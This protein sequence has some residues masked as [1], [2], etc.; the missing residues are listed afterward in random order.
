MPFGATVTA[1]GV[2]FRLW[3]PAAHAVDVGIGDAAKTAHWHAL[4]AKGG[5]WFEAMV[6]EERH[7]TRYRFRIDAGILVPDP[8]SRYNPADV[9]GAS[10]VV[11]PNR[12][13]WDDEDWH[14]R[15]WHEAVIY[16]VHV[17]TFTPGGAFGDV[18]SRLDY[19]AELGVTA[20]ELMPVADFPGKRNWGYDGALLFAP[21]AI[22]G[23]PD[24]LK[25][26]VAAAHRRGLMV[27]LDVV[28][29]HFGPEGNYL[30]VYA[31]QF[32]T[33]RHPTP[34]GAGINFDDADAAQ[35]RAFYVHNALY[36]LEEFS[37]DGLRFDAVHA[38]ADDS[39]P[40]ILTQ[41]AAAVRNGPGRER[42]IRSV[43]RVPSR[44]VGAAR[45]GT[46]DAYFCSRSSAPAWP[47]AATC[48]AVFT[49]PG[50]TTLTRI[51][52]PSTRASDML[53]VSSAAFDAAYATDEPVP[54]TEA[55]EEMLTIEPRLVLSAGAQARIICQGPTRLTRKMPRMSSADSPSRSSCLTN[56]VVPALLTSAS[57]RP[58]LSSTAFAT[59]RQ[60]ASCATSPLTEKIS[61]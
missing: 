52:G 54:S 30:H 50:A 19:V 33:G 25:T 55:T 58:H 38:I 27:L 7:A 42:E 43:Q 23:H 35:V 32:F 29:N 49:K 20:L 41:I 46:T 3:A 34:W 59:R 15:P 22:Y 57:M 48:Q 21:D 61:L 51:S 1:D 17:G 60:S 37:L 24:A 39:T 28:Y 8:A 9:H 56:F 40:D 14:G 53:I 6:Y 12:F 44:S 36:W 47:W 4:K 13:A 26:L 2:R 45:S 5:G 16:E 10:E 18:L 11:D 31:P